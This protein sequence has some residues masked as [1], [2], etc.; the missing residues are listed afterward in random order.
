[1]PQQRALRHVH[2]RHTLFMPSGRRSTCS[3]FCTEII[4][5]SADIVE[6]QSVGAIIYLSSLDTI[7][8]ICAAPSRGMEA[9][10]IARQDDTTPDVGHRF[11]R[12]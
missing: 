11:S 5:I 4:L 9:Y 1:M 7:S 10:N 3:Y 12:W 8:I 6:G 2:E